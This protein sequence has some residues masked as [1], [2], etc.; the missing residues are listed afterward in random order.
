[1][2]GRGVVRLTHATEKAEANYYAVTLDRY[3]IRAELTALR[4]GQ[5][6]PGCTEQEGVHL[7]FFVEFPTNDGG[8]VSVKSGISYVSVEGAGQNP[9]A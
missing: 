6:L 4:N 3:A 8:Q 1:M 2:M 9:I 7:R 5:I